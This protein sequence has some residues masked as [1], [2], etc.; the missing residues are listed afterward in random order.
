MAR[1]ENTNNHENRKVD[2]ENSIIRMN[3]TFALPEGKA[4]LD[5]MRAAV[6]VKLGSPDTGPSLSDIRSAVNK[7]D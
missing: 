3:K 5:A 1:G 7:E 4:G 2:K 6:A